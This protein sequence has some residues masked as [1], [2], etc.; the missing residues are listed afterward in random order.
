MHLPL[1]II[2]SWSQ[3]VEGGDV[4]KGNGNEEGEE[5]MVEEEEEGGEEQVG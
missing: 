4:G 3:Q 2:P 5:E 1:P